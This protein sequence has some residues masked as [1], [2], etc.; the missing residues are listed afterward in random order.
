MNRSP[1][2]FVLI[3]VFCLDWALFDEIIQVPENLSSNVYTPKTLLVAPK[4]SN[5]ISRFNQAKFSRSL[6]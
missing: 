1:I 6:F 4:T 3:E 2:G 5:R